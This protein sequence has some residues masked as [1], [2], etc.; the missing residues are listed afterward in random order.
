[1]KIVRAELTRVRLRLH[2]PLATARGLTDAREGVLLAL[3]S[4]SALVG[5]GETLP[6]AGFSEESP[7]R[8]FETLSGLARVLIGR[9]IEELEALLDMVETLAPEAPTTRAAV[10]VALFDLAARAQGVGVAELLARP[11]RP[12]AQ[13]EVNALVY[14]GKPEV[15]AREALAAVAEGYR[16]IKLKV[17]ALALDLDEARVA[18]VRDAIGSETKIRLDANGGWKEQDAEQ[19]IARFAPYRIE[20]LEQPVD[21]RN[22][23]GLARLSAGS[24]IPIAADEA[25]AGG[26]AFDEIFSRDAASVLVLKPTVLGGLRVSQRVAGRARRAG[27][28]VVVTSAL[29]SAVGLA[30][31]LQ[32]A[33]ALPGPH[34]AAGLATGALLDWDLATPPLPKNGMLSVPDGP[35]IG[36]APLHDCLARCA[37]GITEEITA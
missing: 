4:E 18:A 33:A 5:H 36:V 7:S 19:A 12:R 28:G 34:L 27:W 16:T 21:A 22:L 15:A 37:L 30:A 29:D 8:A 26:Y 3:T 17:G 10:D 23:G 2:T 1:M 6:L 32:L 31:A 35:G 25:L 13:V 11:E 14:A 9:E 20:F 24:P